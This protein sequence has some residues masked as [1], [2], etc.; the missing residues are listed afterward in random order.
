MIKYKTEDYLGWP[1]E[2]D[3]ARDDVSVTWYSDTT[4]L[5]RF[6]TSVYLRECK[7]N[8]SVMLVIQPDG[9]GC[10]YVGMTCPVEPPTRNQHRIVTS[11]LKELGFSP[12]SRRL[13]DGKISITHY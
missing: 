11:Y 8:G 2:Y 3:Y 5:V 12:F 7:W 6:H 13:R 10:E 9:V 1:I 4:A